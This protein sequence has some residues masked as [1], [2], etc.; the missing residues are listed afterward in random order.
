MTSGGERSTYE[1]APEAF[2]G[3]DGGAWA[4]VASEVVCSWPAGHF[5]EN[6]VVD[7]TGVV[8]VSLHA[9]HRIDRYDPVSRRLTSFVVLPSPV[10]GLTFDGRGVLW[11]IGG[12]VGQGPGYV[13]RI[14]RDGAVEEWVEVS[15]ALFM[16]G[17]TLHS[18]GDTLLAC[19][20]LRGRVLAV[21]LSERRWRRWLSHDLLA[22]RGGDLPGANGI[23][24]RNGEAWI[25][26]TERD[27]F[28]RVRIEA[29]GSAGRLLVAVEHVRAD[30]FAFA[31][32]GALYMATHPANTVLRLALDGTRTTVAGPRQGAVGS[33]ACAFG[34]APGETHALYVTTNGGLWAPYQGKVEEAKLLR[35]Q[36][37]EVGV[38]AVAAG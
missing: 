1:Q 4:P 6:L 35:L 27:L 18:D 12:E 29:D 25:S 34:R 14:A 26:V 23:K 20:S 31:A 21:D 16:N 36:V 9:Q 2:A 7:G 10:A 5:A 13:W 22:P 17:C 15:D 30:D 11:A 19:E 24:V 3:H 37:G 33:T 38:A 32:S 8:F 28:V